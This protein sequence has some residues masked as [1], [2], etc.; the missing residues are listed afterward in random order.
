MVLMSRIT[1]VSMS[2]MTKVDIQ[3]DSGT[4]ISEAWA[5][6]GD[7]DCPGG[8]DEMNCKGAPA[9]LTQVNIFIS[10]SGDDVIYEQ[11]KGAVPLSETISKAM[12][13]MV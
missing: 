11:L 2:M 13:A 7:A 5:C 4:C 8:E 6:D 3:C 10:S 12:I 1:T 9:N